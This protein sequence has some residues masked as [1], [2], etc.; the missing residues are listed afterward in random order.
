M[1]YVVYENKKNLKGK[2]VLITEILTAKRV[3]LLNEA[4]GKYGIRNV[5]TTDSGILYKENNRV[6]LYKKK[7]FK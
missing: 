7:V 1:M 5:W 3:P 6:F 4:Q 2:N